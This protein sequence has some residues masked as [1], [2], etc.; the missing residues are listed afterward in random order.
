MYCQYH[1]MPENRYSRT[2][3]ERRRTPQ[4][5]R[6][7]IGETDEIHDGWPYPIRVR[8]LPCFFARSCQTTVR[9]HLREFAWPHDWPWRSVLTARSAL[10]G[11]ARQRKRHPPMCRALTTGL[12]G[13]ASCANVSLERRIF[14]DRNR[15]A[16]RCFQLRTHPHVLFWGSPVVSSSRDC[17]NLRLM[18]CWRTPCRKPNWG[19]NAC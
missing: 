16:D 14:V 4:S 5:V 2:S 6:G 10:S 3:G 11:A 13:V 17:C 1:R 9:W 18:P 7:I 8:R 15:Q 12:S 19:G